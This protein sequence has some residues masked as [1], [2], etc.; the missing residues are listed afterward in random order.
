MTAAIYDSV[1]PPIHGPLPLFLR[2]GLLSQSPTTSSLVI[3]DIYTSHVNVHTNTFNIAAFPHRSRYS[4]AMKELSNGCWLSDQGRQFPIRKAQS[5]GIHFLPEYRIST[6]SEMV[7]PAACFCHYAT[8]RTLQL[9][10]QDS[11]PL[12]ASF[13]VAHRGNTWP[14]TERERDALGHHKSTRSIA[15]NLLVFLTVSFLLYEA[16][17]GT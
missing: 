10:S 7:Y 12:S 1:A 5:W 4:T 11:P 6:R 8:N 14:T 9:V 3:P 16:G 15:Y 17:N 2:C 13:C